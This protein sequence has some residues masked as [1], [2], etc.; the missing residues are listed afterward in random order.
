MID[1][2]SGGRLIAGFVVGGGPE[3]Y[4]FSQNPAM[5][6]ERFYEAHDL[7]IQA[8]TQPGPT[9]YDGKHYRF[10]YLNS[11]PR[12]VQ[13]PHPEIWIPG[14]G[15]LETIEFVARK[16]Y[17][18]M[19]IP[20]FHIDVF[21]KTFRLFRDAC[22]RE[23]YTPT[24]EQMGW[25]TPVYV[26]ESDDQARA[27][28]EEHFWY[29]AKRLLPGIS[30]NPPGYTSLRSIQSMLA[31]GGGNTF[32]SGLETWEQVVNGQYAMIGSPETVTAQLTENLQRLGTG[33]LLALFQIGTLPDA[34]TRRSMELFASEV[35]PKLRATFPSTEAVPA[36]S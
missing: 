11:W 28:F 29:F 12:P 13:Q 9:R 31:N 22:E 10:K 32:V 17:A 25:L 1:C 35:M 7:I 36:A 14:I 21:D 15:S 18:Y 2:V 4:S 34:L 20:F 19:G 26:S 6:R 30:Q 24:P 3:Y 5:A 33:N 23:G 27:E 16:R 8:W